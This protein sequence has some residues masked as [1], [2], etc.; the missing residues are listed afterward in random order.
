MQRDEIV[1]LRARVCSDLTVEMC[2]KQCQLIEPVSKSGEAMHGGW[3]FHVPTEWL[4]PLSEMKK[5]M[6]KR[7]QK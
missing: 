6:D 3:V 1:Y 7:I 2:G 4:V 5:V